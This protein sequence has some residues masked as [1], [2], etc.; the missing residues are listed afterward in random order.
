MYVC[1]CMYVLLNLIIEFLSKFAS[2][3]ERAWITQRER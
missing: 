1:V 3:M 2:R